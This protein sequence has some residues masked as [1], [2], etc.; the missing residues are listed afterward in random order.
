MSGEFEK[1]FA[2]LPKPPYYLV[3]FSSQRTVGDCGYADM[4]Q[5]MLD[6]A[7]QQ[8][9]Y[10]GYESARSADGF[11][12]TNSYW[13]DEDSIRG[14]KQVVDHLAAQKLGRQDWYERYQVRVARVERS[15]SFIRGE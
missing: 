6:L 3:A 7:E 4:A 11:G 14:W 2:P 8:P 10:L 9:G 1:R 12:I 15:Y 13:Q 5:T